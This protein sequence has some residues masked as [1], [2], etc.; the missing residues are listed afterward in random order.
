M[1][2]TENI[3]FHPS[4]EVSYSSLSHSCAEYIAHLTATELSQYK[5][6]CYYK[7]VIGKN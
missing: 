7:V 3:I 4:L 1:M 2:S 6:T 5:T